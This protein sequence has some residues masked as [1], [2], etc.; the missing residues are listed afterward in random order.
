MK[1]D[2]K[3]LDTLQTFVLSLQER[4]SWNTY[5]MGIAILL[6]ARS[7]CER[8]HVGCVLVSGEKN[9]NRI[10]AAG[11]NGH[12]PGLSHKSIVRDGHE[13]A[14]VHAEQNALADAARRGVTT[15]N[16]VAYITHYPCITCAKL[17]L[18]AGIKHCYYHEDYHNDELVAWLFSEANVTLEQF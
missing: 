9:K 4:P 14:T 18:A 11:Y 7:S 10:I 2:K 1:E 16:A 8:L 17:L 15:Q 6:S 5:F 13:Q 12:L 3:L